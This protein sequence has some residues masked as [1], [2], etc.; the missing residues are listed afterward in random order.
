V[1]IATH[2]QFGDSPSNSFLL[3]YDGR[4]SLDDLAAL[5]ER[6]RFGDQPLELLTL[7]ACETAAGDERAALGL[8]GIALRSGARS[9]LATLWPVNDQAASELIAEFYRQLASGG[10][11]KAEAL[12]RARLDDRAAEP[13]TP[14]LLV[15]VQRSAT[16]VAAMRRMR[17]SAR[18]GGGV[19]IATVA[20]IVLTVRWAGGSSAPARG[21]RPPPA[22]AD[23]W[24]GRVLVALVSVTEAHPAA[25]QLSAVRRDARTRD[26][27]AGNLRSA[28]DRR[29][30]LSRY[31][32]AAGQRGA[33][34]ALRHQPA[35][36]IPV[37]IRRRDLER[38]RSARRRAGRLQQ[39]GCR[40][41][42]RGAAC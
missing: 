7:S 22:L 42:R 18:R 30:Y 25:R 23:A 17:V 33:R 6:T 40:P 10:V 34:R 35:H 9:A 39:H 2:A 13:S 37:Q 21:L 12:R 4:L 8:A 1:H 32:R 29:R 24:V 38:R 41:R 11:S 36:R 15:A 26:R 27:T 31:P 28:R 19:R 14:R 3:T 20:A 16:V 5:V